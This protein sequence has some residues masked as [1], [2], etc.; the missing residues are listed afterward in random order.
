[1]VGH[2][3]VRG[4][5]D[6][7]EHVVETDGQGLNILRVERVMKVWLSRVK[8]SCVI[9]SPLVSSAWISSPA[10]ASCELPARRLEHQPGRFGDILYLLQKERKEFLFA[11]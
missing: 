11:G 1:M 9:S 5:L 10:V 4:V 7:V 2:H 3:A 8:I 6:T